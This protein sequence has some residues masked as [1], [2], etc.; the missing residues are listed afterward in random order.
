MNS[1]EFAWMV[2]VEI[3]DAPPPLKKVE[4][5]FDFLEYDPYQ[6]LLSLRHKEYFIH[7]KYGWEKYRVSD[8]TEFTDISRYELFISESIK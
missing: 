3:V 8:T 4:S 2:G 5:V 6:P 7:G 1:K